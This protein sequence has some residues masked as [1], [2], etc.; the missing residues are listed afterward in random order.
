MISV[1]EVF[2]WLHSNPCAYFNLC[3]SDCAARINF[4]YH[5]LL[6]RLVLEPTTVELHQLETFW[7][8]LHRL[9][10]DGAAPSLN[11]VRVHEAYSQGIVNMLMVAKKY[12]VTNITQ[13][14]HP[15][16]Y[17]LKFQIIS[18]VP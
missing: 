10:C 13:T 9:R 3:L 4:S 12:S 11:L 5:P 7:R 16:F 8:M 2:K 6:W 15:E 14:L 17:C 18:T 1:H